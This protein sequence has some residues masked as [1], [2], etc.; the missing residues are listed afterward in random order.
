M[1]K[2]FLR[3]II[4][5][6][7]F[8]CT[9]CG[10]KAALVIS[11]SEH[12]EVTEAADPTQIVM[13]KETTGSTDPTE[14]PA[15]IPVNDPY[16][17]LVNFKHPIYEEPP[18]VLVCD[19]LTADNVYCDPRRHANETAVKALNEMLLA[20]ETEGEFHFIIASAF[21][22]IR[23]QQIMWERKLK[24][25]P[26]YGSDP[27]NNPVKLMPTNCSEHTTGLAFDILC[28]ACPHSDISYANT[29]E[30]RWLAQNAHRFG[31]ILR[32]PNDKQHITGVQFEPWHFRYVG[33]EAAA[34]IYSHSLCL[35]E[36]LGET[37]GR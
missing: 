13:P 16:L 23:E 36:Y 26:T 8:V 35:E 17:V 19:Y 14:T 25:D 27:Y 31:F 18:V 15:P 3:A 30:G 10:E 29:P 9:A 22:Y 33:K 4:M 2:L 37:G 34:Y 5:T 24:E 1:K 32:Y 12:I 20:A 28:D 21:R 7:A 6:A 11:P